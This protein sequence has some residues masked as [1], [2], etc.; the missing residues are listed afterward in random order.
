MRKENEE[1]AKA[2]K[3]A[4]AEKRKP[5]DL[6]G[7]QEELKK[8]FREELEKAKKEIVKTVRAELYRKHG[9]EVPAD[10]EE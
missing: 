4:D 10:D 9:I 6:D 2:E 5:G 7:L 8:I 3:M 1:K